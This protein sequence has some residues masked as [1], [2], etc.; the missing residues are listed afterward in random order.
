MPVD[1]S[2]FEREVDRAIEHA[3]GRTDEKLAA[4]ASSLTRMTDEEVQELFPDT[5]DLRDFVEL[6]KIVKSAEGQNRK[7]SQ[8][9]ENSEKLVG[10]A[11]RLLEAYV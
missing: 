2:E 1:W 4:R 3:A 6:M 7:V 10:V 9:L 5:Q 11:V 8:V